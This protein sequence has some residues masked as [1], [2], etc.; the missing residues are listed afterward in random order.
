MLPIE[1]L[2]LSSSFSNS[3]VLPFKTASKVSSCTSGG[4]LP[5]VIIGDITDL[6]NSNKGPPIIPP[7]IL[8]R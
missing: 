3:S 2:F 8:D 1:P 4:K 7:T 5:V 6:S